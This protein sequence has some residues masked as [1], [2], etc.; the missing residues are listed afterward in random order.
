MTAE[1]VGGIMVEITEG[2]EPEGM[3]LAEVEATAPFRL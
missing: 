3:A 1:T 2:M